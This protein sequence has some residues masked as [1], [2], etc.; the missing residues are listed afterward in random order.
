MDNV[1]IAWISRN[2]IYDFLGLFFQ[3]SRHLSN[4]WETVRGEIHQNSK[5][6]KNTMSSQINQ[7]KSNQKFDF[8]G[9][10]TPARRIGAARHIGATRRIGSRS[11]YRRRS[12]YRDPLGVSEAA[13][14]IGAGWVPS[15]A[16]FPPLTTGHTGRLLNKISFKEHKI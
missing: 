6:N 8:E 11:A 4:I 1:R 7:I 13:R 5:Q 15:L 2:Q 14:R 9:E 16:T 3:I 10:T 12:A